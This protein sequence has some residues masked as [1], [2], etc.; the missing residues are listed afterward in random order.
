MKDSQSEKYKNKRERSSIR[1]HRDTACI[2]SRISIILVHAYHGI[3]LNDGV[4]EH[5]TVWHYSVLS[6]LLLACPSLW[7]LLLLLLVQ[8]AGSMLLSS[9]PTIKLSYLTFK[10]VLLFLCFTHPSIESTSSSSS[11]LASRHS[12]QLVL[13]LLCAYSGWSSQPF[14]RC[15][16]SSPF[17]RSCQS[18]P[19]QSTCLSIRSY[20]PR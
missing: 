4:V 5:S 1:L 17:C 19:S 3:L 16:F 11:L 13:Y 6:C 20:Y 18:P 15:L 12:I 10:L 2:D 8:S 14:K 7:Y 9:T